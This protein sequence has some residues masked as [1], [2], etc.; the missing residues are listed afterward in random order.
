MKQWE[1]HVVCS[2]TNNEHLEAVVAPGQGLLV[3]ARVAVGAALRVDDGATALPKIPHVPL[4]PAQQYTQL[5]R[6]ALGKL[7]HAAGAAGRVAV[8]H[9]RDPQ[10]LGGGAREERG[11]E[12]SNHDAAASSPPSGTCLEVLAERS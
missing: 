11:H 12:G 4:V 5:R 2:E 8:A 1:A 6:I 10:L 7:I 3:R 9:R